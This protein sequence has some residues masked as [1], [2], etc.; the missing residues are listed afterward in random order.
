MAF[1]NKSEAIELLGGTVTEAAK[2]IQIKSSAISQWPDVLP[3]RLQDRVIAACVRSRIAIP[4]EFMKL[5][6]SRSTSETEVAH[7]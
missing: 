7:G 2:A 3:P 6:Q 1:M 4:P 5:T